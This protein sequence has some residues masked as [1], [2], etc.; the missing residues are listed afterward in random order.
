MGKGQRRGDFKARPEDSQGCA[1]RTQCLHHPER[2]R[3][4]KVS[5]FHASELDPNDPS[6]RMRRAIDSP[7]GRMLY[8]RRIATVEPVFANLRHNKRLSRFTLYGTAKV[9]AQWQLFCLVHNIVNVA[10]RGWRR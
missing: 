2:T 1:L 3:A 6:Q 4:R 9:R 7:Q 8:S 5:Q 10:H